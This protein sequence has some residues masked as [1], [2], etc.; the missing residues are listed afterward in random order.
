[1]APGVFFALCR[2]ERLSVGTQVFL[3]GSRFVIFFMT[4]SM[5]RFVRTALDLIQ[6]SIQTITQLRY[7][8]DQIITFIDPFTQKFHSLFKFAHNRTPQFLLIWQA[9]GAGEQ[10]FPTGLQFAVYDTSPQKYIYSK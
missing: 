9:A 6:N 8:H 10:Y 7:L 4:A 3:S 5:E 2:T 1:M